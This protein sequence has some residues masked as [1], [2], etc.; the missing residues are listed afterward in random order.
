MQ[1]YRC[2]CGLVGK[3]PAH[4][5]KS[6]YPLNEKYS[7]NKFVSERIRR[8]KHIFSVKTHIFVETLRVM[9]IP[10]DI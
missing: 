5:S 4:V 7:L 10:K 9:I 8:R 3:V 6:E 2:N 1:K